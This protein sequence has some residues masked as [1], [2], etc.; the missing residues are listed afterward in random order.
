MKRA[1]QFLVDDVRR[2]FELPWTEMVSRL[3]SF[4]GFGATMGRFYLVF[5]AALIAAMP[6]VLLS[7]D[8]DHV[9]GYVAASQLLVNLSWLIIAW[10]G[11]ALVGVTIV[12]VISE[13]RFS[14]VQTAVGSS[15]ARIATWT[16]RLGLPFLLGSVVAWVFGLTGDEGN[17]ASIL[18][19]IAVLQVAM[20]LI[21]LTAM[22]TIESVRVVFRAAE[23][24]PWT[25]RIVCSVGF[26]FVGWLAARRVWHLEPTSVR[27]FESIAPASLAGVDRGAYGAALSEVLFEVPWGVGLAAF[28]LIAGTLTTAWVIRTRR[29]P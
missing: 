28:F 23:G 13:Q 21:S 10:A 24:L 5:L 25:L 2:V 6:A 7:S 14:A 3:E 26:P 1:G 15:V 9:L 27:V 4:R 22:V 17:P 19:S 18:R 20:L 29:R 16:G 12:S 11:S 8:R